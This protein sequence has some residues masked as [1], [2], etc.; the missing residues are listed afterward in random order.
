MEVTPV[1]MNGHMDTSHMQSN[2]PSSLTSSNPTFLRAPK[3]VRARRARRACDP[4]RQKKTRC[5]QQRPKCTCCQAS[6]QQCIYTNERPVQTVKSSRVLQSLEVIGSKLDE[7][8]RSLPFDPLKKARVASPPPSSVR[9]NGRETS[10]VS[11]NRE[12]SLS[13]DSGSEIVSSNNSTNTQDSLGSERKKITNQAVSLTCGAV[14]VQNLFGWPSIKR[15]L[16]KD[17]E[18]Y[19]VTEMEKAGSCVSS[20]GFGRWHTMQDSHARPEH[21][22]G[23][24]VEVGIPAGLQSS[25]LTCP[26][27]AYAGPTIDYY[28]ESYRRNIHILH[29]IVDEAAMRRLAASAKQDHGRCESQLPTSPFN[30]LKR[31]RHETNLPT[32]PPTRERDLSSRALHSESHKVQ[33]MVSDALTLLILALGEICS[34]KKPFRRQAPASAV[35]V[36]ELISLESFDSSCLP[37]E[38][39]DSGPD[40]KLAVSTWNEQEMQMWRRRAPDAVPGRASYIAATEILCRYQDRNHIMLVQ[41]YLLAGLYAGQLTQVCASHAWISKACRVCQVLITS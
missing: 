1:V 36:P 3:A 41:A 12:R 8:L 13:S 35:N 39:S 11:R 31:K 7:V 38:I 28:F 6:D 30:T 22:T 4:C 26:T 9:S 19:N 18:D 16:P 33:S 14:A 2:N 25:V 10:D 23:T 37:P 21:S 17:H 34:C 32:R 27:R 5:D 24:C 40:S 20:H 29:P 15:L